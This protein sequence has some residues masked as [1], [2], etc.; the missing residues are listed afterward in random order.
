VTRSGEVWFPTQKGLAM[1]TPNRLNLNALAPTVLVEEILANDKIIDLRASR[2]DN[3]DIELPA[4]TDRVTL[5]YT[6]LSL[7]FPDK[8]AFEHKLEEFDGEWVSDQDQRRAYDYTSLWPGRYVFRVR[9]ANN[10]GVWNRKGVEV[11]FYLAPRFYQTYPFYGMSMLA[12]AGVVA[13]V[14]R[15][16]LQQLQQRERELA[17]LV[18]ERTREIRRQVKILDEQAQEIELANDELKGKNQLIEEE[19]MKSERL[20]LNILP[21][22]VAERLKS[23]ERIIADKF[24]SVTVAFADIVGFTKMSAQISPEHLVENLSMIFTNFDQLAAQ[25]NLEKIK[26]I[27]DAYMVVGGLPKPSTDHAERMAD[28]ALALQRTITELMGTGDDSIS[29]RVGLHTGPVVAG[30]IGVQKFSYD[31]WGDTVNTASR[32]ESS[33][34][35]RMIHCTEDVYVLLKDK[36]IFQERGEL[37]IKGK[38]MMRTYFLIGRKTA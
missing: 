19:R 33:G 31:I 9:A 32:M 1:T 13:W 12:I 30:V 16:R 15:M 20:L 29:V 17:N 24:D 37:A 7:L 3:G 11:A 10:D 34:E 26:T 21:P 22:A 35:P 6:A 25:Y 18:N 38:G 8:V 36:F 23:G 27:G 2:N 28:M 4:G 14:F 5:R